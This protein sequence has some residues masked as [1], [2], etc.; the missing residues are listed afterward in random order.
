[1]TSATGL[2]SLQEDST[3]LTVSPTDTS[4][5]SKYEFYLKATQGTVS[6]FTS[7]K[8]LIV[9]CPTS[10]GI[11]VTIGAYPSTYTSTQSVVA[12]S[13]ADTRFYLPA[14]TS[15]EATVCPVSLTVSS[16]TGSVTSMSTLTAPV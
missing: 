14:F 8:T 5:E 9:G 12:N 16:T 11:T 7:M 4:I 3:T 13:A 1:V 6:E 2:D 10:S 15:S